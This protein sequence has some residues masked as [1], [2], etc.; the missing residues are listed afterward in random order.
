[1]GRIWLSLVFLS[2]CAQSS[3]AMA[4]DEEVQ[5]A[6]DPLFELS[7]GTTQSFVRPDRA[8][9]EGTVLM[10]TTSATFLGEVFMWPTFRLAALYNIPL[11]TDRVYV[12]DEL[13][14]SITYP[15]FGLGVSWSPVLYTFRRRSRIEVQ[16]AAFAG[17]TLNLDNP[18]VFPLLASRVHLM[19]NASTGVGV[20][21]GTA[22]AFRV[23]TLSLIYG[24][25]YRF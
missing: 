11:S 1:M 17:A 18:R 19:Q 22:F 9:D 10:P 2:V 25:G 21:V 12:E 16:M 3:W 5:V 15:S 6:E 8:L 24:V 4:H 14:E 20:Y 13:Q 7:F 23:E